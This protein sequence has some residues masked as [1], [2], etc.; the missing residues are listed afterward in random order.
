[1]Y[2]NDR[3]R[4]LKEKLLGA[5]QG[6]PRALLLAG[7]VQEAIEAMVFVTARDALVPIL[8][9]EL[10]QAARPVPGEPLLKLR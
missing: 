7:N 10:V 5:V 9:E 1:V 6:N 8:D 4:H 2:G 3:D